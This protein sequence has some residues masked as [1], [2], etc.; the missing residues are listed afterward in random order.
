MKLRIAVVAGI[1]A[2]GVFGVG[3]AA[4]EPRQD[5]LP[6]ECIAQALRNESLQPGG[7]AGYSDPRCS[8]VMKNR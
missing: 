8:E 3:T 1:V 5:P 2:A 6:S 7:Y 4:A